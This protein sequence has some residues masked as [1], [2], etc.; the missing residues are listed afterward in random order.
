MR[1]LVLRR[2]IL[3]RRLRRQVVRRA[4]RTP[5]GPRPRSWWP[6]HLGWALELHR[7]SVRWR[8]LMR[9]W[10][11]VLHVMRR[12]ALVLLHMVRRSMWRTW[13]WTTHL[14]MW[15]GA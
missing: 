7:R 10:T 9:R 1:H 15:P 13:W 11:L 3:R 14:M 5:L 8:A 6:L 12:R 4:A 2:A